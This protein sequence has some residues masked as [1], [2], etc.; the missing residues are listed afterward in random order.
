MA[1]FWEKVVQSYKL[2]MSLHVIFHQFYLKTSQLRLYKIQT[3]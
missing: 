1:M 3:I 2:K